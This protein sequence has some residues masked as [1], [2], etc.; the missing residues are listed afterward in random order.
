MES[1]TP[2]Q[3]ASE[4]A[5]IYVNG[6]AVSENPWTKKAFLAGYQAAIEERRRKSE[7]L[8]RLLEEAKHRG[9]K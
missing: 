5:T 8:F 1:K 7:E 6:E 4:Y 3:M 2:E 9:Q